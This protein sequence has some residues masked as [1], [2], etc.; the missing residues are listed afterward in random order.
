MS[1]ANEQAAIDAL[2][3]VSVDPADLAGSQSRLLD[4]V[5]QLSVDAPGSKTVL[6]SG[7]ID[8]VH[9]SEIINQ[10]MGNPD[11]RLIDKTMAAEVLSSDA[12]KAKVAQAFNEIPDAATRVRRI[13]RATISEAHCAG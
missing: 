6:Y 12:F 5:K 13:G 4:F 9:A 1:F 10:M 7:Y 3:A 11:V 8:G 2:A